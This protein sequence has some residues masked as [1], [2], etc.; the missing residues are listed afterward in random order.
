ME[1]EELLQKYCETENRIVPIKDFLENKKDTSGYKGLYKGIITLNSP[2]V[3]KPEILFIGINAGAGAYN[4]K[5]P[6]RNE[7]PLRM[8]GEDEMCLKEL[9]LYEKGN[10]RGYFKNKKEWVPYEWYQRNQRVNNTFPKNMIDLLYDIAKLKFTDDYKA[11]KYDNKKLPFWYE[12]F[13]QKIMYTNL[14]PIATTN[15]ADLKKIHEKLA[16]EEELQKYWEESS[17]K[18]TSINEWVVRKYF[19]SRAYELVKLVQPKVIVLMGKSAYNDF[20]DS[21]FKGII[22]SGKKQI[23]DK[24]VPLVGFSRR[25]QWSGHIPEIAKE[26]VKIT[27]PVT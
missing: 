18:D 9:N 23:D 16:G 12:N 24:L 20:V 11:E 8:V 26:N 3:F 14:Y 4:I 7:T 21:N 19:I 22:H 5:N 17:G 2:L 15:T 6:T 1:K 13:G 27:S 10:A 25:G